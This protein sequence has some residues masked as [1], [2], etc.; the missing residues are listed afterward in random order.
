LLIASRTSHAPASSSE[1]AGRLLA[2][3]QEL[4]PEITAC[5]LEMEAAGTV[6]SHLVDRL[7]A[8][9]VFRMFV[10]HRDGGL[11]LDLPAGLDIV[12]T[13]AK[14]EGSI[15][16]IVGIA[17]GGALLTPFLRRETYRSIY[18][19]GPDTIIAGSGQP[20]GTA[21]AVPEGWRVNGRWGYVSACQHADW[22]I[23]FCVMHEGGNPMTD[24]TG[25][26]VMR[27]FFLAAEQWQIEETWNAVGLKGTGSHD[28]LLRDK[29]V[30]ASN[31]F[32][33]GNSAQCIPGVLHLLLGAIS[34]GIAEGAL[35]DL[36]AYANIGRQS[37]RAAVPMRE[38]ELFQFELGR[39]AAE[40]DAARSFLESQAASHWRHAQA[41]TL[42]DEA[43]AT[44]S[45]QSAIWLVSVCVR[46][47]DTCFRLG[48]S[49]VV[50]VTSPLQRRMRD[51]H[52]AAQHA[53]VQQRNYVSGG[54]LLLKNS[55]R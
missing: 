54:K 49:G 37:V 34:V 36:V 38:S 16:W 13:L 20:P 52:T 9:G 4:A 21:E 25:A 24:A 41:G 26:A 11:G 2:D 40:L 18:Q 8:I 55:D 6:P 47:A 35:A 44:K 28:I 43:T 5:A 53:I 1:T 12:R 39:V 17:S 23:G 19:S 29:I 31:F 48:G 33:P 3:I 14:I 46:A 45:I 51:L 27:G 7:K 30:P 22:I 15:G 50:Y 32:E 10:P 42:K